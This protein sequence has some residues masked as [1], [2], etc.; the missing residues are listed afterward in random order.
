MHAAGSRILLLRF[1]GLGDLLAV[2]P[3]ISWIRKSRRNS[4][5]SLV[6]RKEYG[7]LFLESG[8]VDEIVSIDE[9]DVGLL[10]RGPSGADTD[11]PRWLDN[12]SFVLGWMQKAPK[13]DMV[14][15]IRSFGAVDVRILWP[16]EGLRIA[17][18]RHFF[19]ETKRLFPLDGSEFPDF[20]TC[21]RLA[22]EGRWPE[23]TRGAARPFP[24]EK[25]GFV[26]VHPGSGGSFKCWPM[27]NFV[28]I[29][30]RLAGE[31]IPGVWITGE[32][33]EESSIAGR[34]Q[35]EPLPEGWT[36]I[37][38]PPI[39]ELA[40]LL[41]KSALYLG[42]DSGVTHLAAACGVPVLA[43][44]REDLEIAWKPYGRSTTLSS[45]TLEGIGIER[46]WSAIKGAF[47]DEEKY[48]KS[49]FDY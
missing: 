26:A 36:W 16:P 31:G 35:K 2:L 22:S 46:V 42:N 17:L 28:G 13:A 29:V 34:L 12:V 8:I 49:S 3:A 20:E 48:K 47:V 37:R 5:L 43:L 38:R 30:R 41:A 25:R 10:F 6:C 14:E 24:G 21:A 44:F 15:T 39:M 7:E 32:A 23:N 1:G 18:S 40:G 9:R 19:E 33:E 45:R 11:R 4:F 27:E